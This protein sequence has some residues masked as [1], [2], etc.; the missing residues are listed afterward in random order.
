M[1]AVTSAAV[2]TTKFLFDMCHCT[3]D[4]DVV[5]GNFS[6]ILGILHMYRHVNVQLY[7]FQGMNCIQPRPMSG[8]NYQHST[9]YTLMSSHS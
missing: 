5:T 9:K 1:L 3:V 2:A 7:M 6:F 4:S 8:L